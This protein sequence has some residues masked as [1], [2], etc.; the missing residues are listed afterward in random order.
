MYEPHFLGAGLQVSFAGRHPYPLVEPR[1][2]V[3]QAIARLFLMRA[4][5][6]VR[7]RLLTPWSDSRIVRLAKRS[8]AVIL[9][10]VDSP[11]L[12]SRLRATK[13]ALVYDLADD[14]CVDAKG[15]ARPDVVAS[16]GTVDA[17]TVNSGSAADYARRFGPPVHVWPEAAYVEAFDQRRSAAQRGNGPV[18]LG[19][20]GSPS[21]VCNLWLV[22]EAVE[23]VARRH[24][25]IRLR[26]VGVP[27]GHEI[28]RRFRH[29]AVSARA[30]YDEKEMIEEVLG[31]DIGLYPM[32][33]IEENVAHGLSKALIY[34][35][36]G[37]V[38]VGSPVGNRG[39]LLRHGTMGFVADGREEWID[40]L[41]RLVVDTSLR[42]RIRE[43][44]LAH[45]RETNS[46]AKSFDAIRA[47]LRD[48]W[49]RP[50]GAS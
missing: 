28:L 34:M 40:V 49:D 39:Q 32:Y 14:V 13:A 38:V 46:L 19:W 37:A 6:R 31:M 42:E 18:T 5:E 36:G 1:T 48:L 43:A 20:I 24:P 35:A 26:L 50:P 44:A 12:V 29:C 21:T 27:P 8:H 30:S 4:F 3:R 41:D 11:K 10:K 16:L 47:V 7:D 17:I 15:R 22:L 9:V 2:R 25:G 33:D 23:E 45:V